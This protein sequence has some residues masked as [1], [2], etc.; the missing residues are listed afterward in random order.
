M[1][2]E[3]NPSGIDDRFLAGL[4]RSFGVRWTRSMYRWHLRREWRGRPPDLLVL[5]ERGRL[6]S[7]VGVNYRHLRLRDGARL[8][9]GVLSGAWTLP[10]RRGRGLIQRLFLAASRRMAR[11]GGT[12]AIGFV[13]AGSGSHRAM[14]RL[15]CESIP[16]A[17]LSAPPE[18]RPAGDRGPR[19]PVRTINAREAHRWG[20]RGIPRST[21]RFD[22]SCDEDWRS[23]FIDRPFPVQSLSVEGCRVVV[24]RAR[25]TDR[26]LWISGPSARRAR[27]VERLAARAARRRRGFFAFLFGDLERS[28]GDMPG[29]TRTSGALV[30]L[31]ASRARLATALSLPPSAAARGHESLASP[32]SPWFLGPWEIQGGDR[33]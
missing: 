11:N 30:I 16:S 13:T 10:S 23:Q 12:L 1:T 5:R 8:E 32:G 28:I 25:D 7:G 15:G 26:L 9:V 17:Y 2:L 4:N 21:V 3:V 14:T 31:V 18:R 22:Y 29:F 20:V 6:V 33:M 27:A 24:E 19:L